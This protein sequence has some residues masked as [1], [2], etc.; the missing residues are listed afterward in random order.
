MK[1]KSYGWPGEEDL[2]FFCPLSF[3]FF[4]LTNRGSNPTLLARKPRLSNFS[5]FL[6]FF[7]LSLAALAKHS[8]LTLDPDLRTLERWEL[9]TNFTPSYH[10]FCWSSG[11]NDPILEWIRC[12]KWDRRRNSISWQPILSISISETETNQTRGT[13]KV[14]AFQER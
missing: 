6:V 7:F 3:I 2:F 11:Y 8:Y 5:S 14:A 9:S 1:V 4:I 10:L 13:D 12:I